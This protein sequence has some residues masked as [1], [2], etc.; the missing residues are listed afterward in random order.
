MMLHQDPAY[1]LAAGATLPVVCIA[2]VGL[3]FDTRRVHKATYGPDDWLALLAL[4]ALVSIQLVSMEYCSLSY[5]C[6]SFW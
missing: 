6:R 5:R 4:L 2:V 3:R 1:A